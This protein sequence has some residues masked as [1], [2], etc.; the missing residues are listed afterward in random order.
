VKRSPQ[1]CRE[2]PIGSDVTPEAALRGRHPIK[3]K[4]S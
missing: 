2:R 4:S 1:G 3:E